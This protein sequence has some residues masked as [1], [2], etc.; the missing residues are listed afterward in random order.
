[1]QGDNLAA[2]DNDSNQQKMHEQKTHEQKTH[3]I[4]AACE[5]TETMVVKNVL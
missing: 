2:H 1:M 5:N 4:T 3:V